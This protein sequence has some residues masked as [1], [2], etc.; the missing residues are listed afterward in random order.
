MSI[1]ISLVNNDL[2]SSKTPTK[3]GIGVFTQFSFFF[4]LKD[5]QNTM[6]IPIMAGL[7]NV[8]IINSDS[9]IL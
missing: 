9:Q 1:K 8:I 7:N 5:T 6:K 3:H 4:I 2:S